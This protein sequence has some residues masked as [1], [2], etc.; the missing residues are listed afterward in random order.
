MP[1]LHC[2]A[3]AEAELEYIAERIDQLVKQVS[4]AIK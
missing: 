4:G 3:T 1:E 2:F